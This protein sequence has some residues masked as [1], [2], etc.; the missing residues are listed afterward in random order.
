M[1]ESFLQKKMPRENWED[2]LFVVKLLMS[3]YMAA[4]KGRKLKFPL[5]GLENFI[6]QVAKGKWNPRSVID[7]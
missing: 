2:G 4:G 5:A 3:C 6:P 1:V 7:E